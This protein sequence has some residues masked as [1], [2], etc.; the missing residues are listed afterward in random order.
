MGADLSGSDK[1]KNKRGLHAAFIGAQVE[2]ITIRPCARPFRAW[3]PNKP[4]SCHLSISSTDPLGIALTTDDWCVMYESTA[5][6]SPPPR[7][8][9][10]LVAD[11]IELAILTSTPCPRSITA[12]SSTSDQ[13]DESRSPFT[14]PLCSTHTSAWSWTTHLLYV[15]KFFHSIA[16][17]LLLETLT[18]GSPR[19]AASFF[20]STRDVS[21]VR[22]AWLGN[23]SAAAREGGVSVDPIELKLEEAAW[24]EECSSGF[25]VGHAYASRLKTK[26]KV[27]ER[28][29]SRERQYRS[30]SVYWAEE[31]LMGGE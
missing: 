16:L 7:L 14:T 29:K 25:V 15:S 24:Y 18:L 2:S 13:V 10:E 28:G 17:P 1:E 20:T 11:I 8:P 27:R 3:L 6:S 9:A 12:S 4:Q 23:L 19:A 5:L 22:R 31:E 26:R 21:K 30:I